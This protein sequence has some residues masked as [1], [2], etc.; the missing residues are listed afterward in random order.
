MASSMTARSDIA[1]RLR[2]ASGLVLMT[3]ACTHLLNHALG[4]HSLAA[5]EAGGRIFTAVWRTPPA[6]L[7]LYA[8]F[9]THVTLAVGKLWRRRS[10]RMP[11]W[12]TIQLLL[13]IL[14][15]FWLIVHVIGTRGTH[16]HFG[17]DDSYT[18]VLNALWP[19]RAWRQSF[20]LTLVWLH[21]C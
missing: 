8:A 16:Q 7:L 12:E 11:P 19:D 10:L 3:F 1:T 4:I 9:A 15:P 6:T 18:Y 13:G 17:V 5:M 14:I 20:M 2:L 21:G